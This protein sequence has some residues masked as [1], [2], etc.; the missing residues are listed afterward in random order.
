[1][2][3]DRPFIEKT[4]LA[5]QITVKAL[6]EKMGTSEDYVL[7]WLSGE[8]DARNGTRMRMAA[9][10]G[11]DANSLI[12]GEGDDPQPRPTNELLYPPPSDPKP[13]PPK[14]QEILVPLGPELC[15]EVRGPVLSQFDWLRMVRMLEVMGPGYWKKGDPP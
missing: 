15:V 3:L 9:E 4:M 11:V 10:L 2:K 12:L 1:M 14:M 6:A 5:K 8:R 13:E 7:A